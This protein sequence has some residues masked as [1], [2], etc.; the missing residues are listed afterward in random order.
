MPLKDQKATEESK[1]PPDMPRNPPTE[2]TATPADDRALGYLCRG[3]SLRVNAT[4]WIIIL[5]IVII[6]LLVVIIIVIYGM[7]K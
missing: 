7:I 3:H 6:I 2:I 5:S 1:K 4:L